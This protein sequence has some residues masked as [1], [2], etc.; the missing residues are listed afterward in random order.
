EELIKL[1]VRF[2][3]STEEAAAIVYRKT[4]MTLGAVLRDLK[5][6]NSP[7]V[8][9]RIAKNL[10]VDLSDGDEYNAMLEDDDVEFEHA[11]AILRACGK[12][13]GDAVSA[14]NMHEKFSSVDEV[15]DIF[16]S[17]SKAGFTNEEIMS[18]I[19][20][21]DI[22][23]DNPYAT[24]VQDAIE[25]KVP[26]AEIVAF[27]QKENIDP[28]GLDDE[29]REAEMGIQNRIDILHGLIHAE[30]RPTVEETVTAEPKA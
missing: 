4:D 9:A 24:I 2:G 29:M 19:C 15:E 10:D 14:E 6:L 7:E 18:G 27:L 13:A 1:P 17:L 23:N 8:C 30:K 21:S 5:L 28:D 3:C 25:H 20:S 12:T 16:E 26:M 22:F 11:A